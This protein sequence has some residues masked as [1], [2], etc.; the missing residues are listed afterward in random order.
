MI[1]FNTI[2]FEEKRLF[3][4]YIIVRIIPGPKN[5]PVFLGG[6]L[7]L[8]LARRFWNHTCTR[9]SLKQ[10]FR[11]SSSLAKTSNRTKEKLHFKGYG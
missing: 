9:D 1:N 7:F 3:K 4:I 11:A 8:H 2:L 5:G 6:S 10:S